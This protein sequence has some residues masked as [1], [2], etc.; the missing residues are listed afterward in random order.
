[1]R[2]LA[3]TMNDRQNSRTRTR[4]I[5]SRLFGLCILVLLAF[6]GSSWSH[7]PLFEGT[8]FLVGVLLA[9]TGFC[10]RLWCLSYIAGRKK[11][12]LVTTGPYSLCRHPLYFFSLVGG[13]GLSLCTETLMIPLLF[14]VAFAL[15]YPHVLRGEE[16]FLSDNFP[17]Y[18]SYKLRVPLFF[19]RWSNFTEGDVMINVCAFRREIVAAGAFL[20]FIGVIEFVEILHDVNI[21][22]TYFLI[23]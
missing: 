15:Y 8:L 6:G 4:L 21:L 5:G 16:A 20:S 2:N 23:P 9:V 13:I 11:R 18:E 7:S 17:E 3:P 22:P 10:G 14:V 1:M 19:P 12:V